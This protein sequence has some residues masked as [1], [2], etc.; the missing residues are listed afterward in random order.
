MTTTIGLDTRL[1]GTKHAGLGRYIKTLAARIPAH[2]PAD[3]QLV[4]FVRDASQQQE[5]IDEMN[6]TGWQTEKIAHCRQKIRFVSADVAHYSLAE[7]VQLPALYAAANL[8][9]L[10]AP[11]FNAPYWPRVPRLLVT[12][13]D[14]L[15]HES[16]GLHVTTQSPLKYYVKYAA[17]RLLVDRVVAVSKKIIVPSH[18]IETTVKHFYPQAADKIITVY[19]GVT[20]LKNIQ[21]CPPD[22]QMPN[23]YL[24]Y[25][26]SLY[27]HKNVPLILQAL[28][29]LPNQHLVI[30]SARD[31][32]WQ[33]TQDLISKLKIDS[34]VIFLGQVPDAQLKY[35]YT[36]AK[37]LVQ[38]SFSEGFGLTGIEAMFQGT[39]VL[40]SDTPI[41]HEVYGQHYFSFDPHSWQSFLA[42]ID[43]LEKTDLSELKQRM[44]GWTHRYD[45]DSAAQ[46]IATIYQEILS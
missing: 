40:A 27:P 4:Y 43:R 39:P 6:A 44:T 28:T 17:Y 15:W 1:A 2:L 29:K 46:Q 37:A 25:V 20:D 11:H 42:A 3:W 14:L 38:P 16:R 19:N 23:N 34:Q 26:G 24:L 5:I 41:F 21:D 13:Q 8:D 33:R 45:W 12:I 10:H 18:Q 7:Q 35:L 22:V 31:V 9:L 36:H 30:V 32:F